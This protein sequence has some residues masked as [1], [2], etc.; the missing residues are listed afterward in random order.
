MR[1]QKWKNNQL[2]DGGRVLVEVEDKLQNAVYIYMD[3]NNFCFYYRNSLL[4]KHFK[5][6]IYFAH[7]TQ[8]IYI[9]KSIK[10]RKL[11]H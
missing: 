3:Y 1:I 7:L 2:I 11:P 9:R 10:L 5:L 4:Y 6:D 8:L